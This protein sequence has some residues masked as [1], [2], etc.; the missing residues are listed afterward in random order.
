VLAG[1]TFFTQALFVRFFGLEDKAME[2]R[3]WWF[4]EVDKCLDR[5][6]QCIQLCSAFVWVWMHVDAIYKEK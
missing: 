2:G 5:E 3:V 6:W 1:S 4:S